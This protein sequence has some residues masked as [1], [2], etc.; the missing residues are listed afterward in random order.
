[1][2][3][4]NC[5]KCTTTLRLPDDLPAGKRVR[6]PECETKF[7]KPEAD[8]PARPSRRREP[9]RDDDRGDDPPRR[10]KSKG[11]RPQKKSNA[12]VIIGAALAAVLLL[13]G[14]AVAA[15]LMWT[16]KS[17]DNPTGPPPA[18]ANPNAPGP[19]AGPR[20][21][22]PGPGKAKAPP[23]PAGGNRVTGF[24]IGNLVMEIEGEDIDGQTFKLSDYRGKVVVL[25][26]WGHW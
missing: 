18:V 17:D 21:E 23:P 24:E 16:D 7:L 8:E 5:P 19:V 1:M 22:L 2:P 14:G 6:C 11:R 10:T 20:I 9:S 26:F 13:G 4:V 12:P 3:K 25:D 15:V